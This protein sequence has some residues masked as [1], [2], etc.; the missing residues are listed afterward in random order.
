MARPQPFATRSPTRSHGLLLKRR[1]SYSHI[2]KFLTDSGLLYDRV[3]L[4]ESFPMGPCSTSGDKNSLIDMTS[5]LTT[6]IATSALSRETP[7]KETPETAETHVEKLLKTL[8]VRIGETLKRLRS[9]GAGRW[10]LVW[11][12]GGRKWVLRSSKVV[13]VACL[14]VFDL[15]TRQ[16]SNISATKIRQKIT[17]RTI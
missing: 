16:R 9:T 5:D 10:W 13:N 14:T 3:R 2:C 11:V 4:D 1:G 12:S 17:Y 8:W 6:A 7:T 15:S